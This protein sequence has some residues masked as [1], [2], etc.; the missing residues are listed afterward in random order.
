MKNSTPLAAWSFWAWEMGHMEEL[1][2]ALSPMPYAPSD[3]ENNLVHPLKE[4][5]FPVAFNESSVGAYI[6]MSIKIYVFIDT[7]IS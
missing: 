5:E 6:C 4:I 7:K 2:D 3:G 1:T